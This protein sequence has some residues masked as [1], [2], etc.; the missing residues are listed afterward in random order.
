MSWARREGALISEEVVV[1]TP[2][3][4]A[5]CLLARC[6]GDLRTALALA[7]RR[8][9]APRHRRHFHVQA[10]VAFTRESNY[11][12]D[13][14]PGVFIVNV[15]T[16]EEK[17][18]TD[19]NKAGTGSIDD[20]SWWSPDETYLLLNL[21]R[22]EEARGLYRILTDGTSTVEVDF[23]SALSDEIWY[24]AQPFNLLW[25]DGTHIIGTPFVFTEDAALGGEP[26]VVR[27]ELN[28]ALDT[29]IAG[30]QVAEEVL[31][32][33]NVPGQSVWVHTSDG[34]EFVLL[35]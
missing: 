25:L 9:P 26:L 34:V 13:V 8:R 5:F 12:L 27:Y 3:R 30:A 16:G 24:E 15:A 7:R 4:R 2:G 6:R 22:D 1:R 14:T 21:Q 29:I 31:V 23:A 28:G 20:K 35:L 11:N 18:V 32:G 17:Q 10:K 33:W 19:I